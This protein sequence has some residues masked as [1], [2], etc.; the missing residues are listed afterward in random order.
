ME[1]NKDD[2]VV[3][4]DSSEVVSLDLNEQQQQQQQQQQQEALAGD[5]IDDQ[6]Q[7]MD[8]DPGQKLGVWVQESDHG[9]VMEL[10][11]DGSNS[12]HHGEIEGLDLELR[13]GQSAV[14][15]KKT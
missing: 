5:D 6:D 12:S 11:I 3:E 2:V 7:D 14:E 10:S 13:L 1:D 4:S 15:K 8:K 9:K